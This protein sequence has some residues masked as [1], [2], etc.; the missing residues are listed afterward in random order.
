MKKAKLLLTIFL[1][2]V[3]ALAG[4]TKA[5]GSK[6]KSENETNKEQQSDANSDYGKVTIKNGDRTL[7]FTKMPEKVITINMAAT[8][9]M[10]LLGLEDKLVGRNIRTNEA[11]VPLPQ[12][13]KQFNKVPEIDSTLELA[14]ASQSDFMVGQVGTFKDST[15]GSMDMLNEKGINTYAL[16]GTLDNDE[17]IENVYEDIESL[18][19]IFKVE[20]RA[21]KLIDEAKSYISKITE[22][23]STIGD[24]KKLKVYVVDSFKGN[25][26]YTTSSGLESNLIELAGG[27]N[28]T[29]GKSDSRW[30]N[31]S[32]ESIVEADPDLIIFNDYGTQTLEEKEAFI[33]ENP[34]LKD[35]KAV[36]D[37]RFLVV[38]LVEV[39]QDIRATTTCHKFAENF[40]PELFK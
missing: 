35:V 12:I 29:K 10:L 1:I 25:E 7:T 23:T 3:L 19:K 2:S 21:K 22:K 9:N 39:M 15:W 13:E 37:D 32:V 31:T 36:K 6:V 8:E 33:K 20:D 40:Y 5:D 27:I 18:G 30:F 28:V 16:S 4:C 17:T 34:A 14:V 38:P 24:D 26:I 11:E